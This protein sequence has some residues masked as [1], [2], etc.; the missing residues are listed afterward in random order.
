M[1]ENKNLNNLIKCWKDSA[2]NAHN[3]PDESRTAE[4]WNKRSDTFGLDREGGR[5]HKRTENIF[6]LLNE[7]GFEPKGAKVLDIG[8][9]PGTLA[10]PLAEAGAEVTAVDI[11]SGML[12][13]LRATA[14]EEN[15]TIDAK[16][17]S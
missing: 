16:E 9:G 17:L 15:L 14:K 8:C 2:P 7:A 12:D 11:A 10:I 13:R 1:D 6:A 5:M 3:P 4:M